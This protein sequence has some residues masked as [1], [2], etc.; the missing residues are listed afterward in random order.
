MTTELTTTTVSDSQLDL[1]RKTIAA[2]ATPE[3]LDLFLYDCKRRGVHPLDK[4]LHFTK[5][6]GKYV[7]ICS[8]DLMRTRAA[9]SGEYAGNDDAVF[10]GTIGKDFAASV[11]V[12]RLVQGQR[13]PFTAT[14]RLAE[15]MPPS[16]QDAM[17]RKMPHVMLAK[18]AEALALRKAFPAQLGALYVGEE[19][20]QAGRQDDPRAIAEDAPA[21]P[22]T[23]APPRN[24]T[25]PA[26]ATP[27]PST[28]TGATT[29]RG[30]I[31]RTTIKEGNKN[32]K[33]WQLT[34][35]QIASDELG[36]AWYNT[37]DTVVGDV[38]R[39]ALHQQ[40]QFLWKPGK[41]RADGTPSRDLVDI[42]AVLF[43]E[44]P[45]PDDEPGADG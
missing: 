29:S 7:P 39:S 16:G 21:P 6:G 43:D 33:A 17:W 31:E 44:A 38:A 36:T 45:L 15:Y 12:W 1:V 9:D 18:C 27:P 19:L 30:V 20:D 35:V 10:T 8:I 4:L 5:R 42:D 32:G 24:V 25:P 41:A 13:C 3:E 34:G 11:T 23:K 26:K 37:F 2:A 22:A 40:V 14:A 28:A